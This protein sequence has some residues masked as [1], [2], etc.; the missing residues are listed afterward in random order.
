M[1][2]FGDSYKGQRKGE[3]SQRLDGNGRY[4]FKNGDVFI[5]S[6]VDGQFHGKGVI[7]FSGSVGGRFEGEW[8]NGIALRGEYVFEDGLV[9]K[10]KD[11]S[12]AIGPD[13]RLFS[14]HQ[15]GLQGAK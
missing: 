9:F 5:G 12:Y 8:K 6:L 13:R 10:D 2:L 4:I 11:W 14:E 15:T 1:D 3:H 7:L